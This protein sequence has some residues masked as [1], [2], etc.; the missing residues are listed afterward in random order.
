MLHGWYYKLLDEEFGPVPFDALAEIARAGTISRE[1]LVREGLRGRWQRAVDVYGLFTSTDEWTDLLSG[2][3]GET[4]EESAAN[5][6]QPEKSELTVDEFDQRDSGPVASDLGWYVRSPKHEFG[7]VPLF[8]LVL[9]ASEGRIA[10]TDEVRQGSHGDWVDAASV[11][12]L[13]AALVLQKPNSRRA[14]T[15]SKSA[16]D[17]DFEVDV[18]MAAAP[19]GPPPT[20]VPSIPLRERVVE[21]Q[22]SAPIDQP[23]SV[24]ETSTPEIIPDFESRRARIVPVVADKRSTAPPRARTRTVSASPGGAKIAVGL[25]AAAIG[26][27]LIAIVAFGGSERTQYAQLDEVWQEIRGLR[28]RRASD[29]EWSA[30]AAEARE[31]VQPIV[32][33]LKRTAHADDPVRQHLLWAAEDYLLP[34]LD[35]ARAAPSESEKRFAEH[36]TEARRLMK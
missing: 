13:L 15:A 24:H 1:D 17:A 33:N 6:V 4:P 5:A 16:N 10:E 23:A 32:K 12:D 22:T 21:V 29:Q 27:S 19:P 3:A 11:P 14:P 2:F 8:D 36:M 25:A 7:P 31:K 28:D 34:M 18:P 20:T 35:D 9:M 30:F 26:L